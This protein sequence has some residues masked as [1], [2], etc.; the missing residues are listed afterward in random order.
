M[1]QARPT[2]KSPAQLNR[3]IAEA[4]RRKPKSPTRSRRARP[5]HATVKRGKGNGKQA[6]ILMVANDAALSDQI[7]RAV[8][9]LAQ[10][11]QRTIA[12][13]YSTVTP[14]SAEE[15]D[16]ADRGWVDEEGDAIEIDMLAIEDQAEAG[17]QAPVTDAIVKSAVRWL[18]DR[19]AYETSSSS[20]HPG[21]WY[22]S[23]SEVSD[24]ST[25]EERSEDF[26][27]RNF[28]EEEERR[29]FDEF[30]RGRRR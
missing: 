23:P 19:G 12:T 30:K 17:S 24:Y 10:S 16:F 15:S 28:T 8:K 4:L 20:Y 2:K 25:G 29:I 14:E 13:S 1:P 27:L 7:D 26:F 11:K 22:S 18:R 6:E 9:L 5:T 3:E 21:V